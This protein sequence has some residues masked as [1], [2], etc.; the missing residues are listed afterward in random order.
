MSNGASFF[1][2]SKPRSSASRISSAYDDDENA[3]AGPSSSS[4]RLGT[5]KGSTTNS[6]IPSGREEVDHEEEEQGASSVIFRARAKGVRGAQSSSPA[7]SSKTATGR[8]QA[9]SLK[10]RSSA[11]A[12]DEDDA[13]DD[14][15]AI[16]IRRSKPNTAGAQST[17]T[18]PGASSLSTTSTATPKRSTPLRP[19]SFHI[20]A[21]DTVDT[22]SDATSTL[23][24][25]K[26]LEELRSSTPT[27]R[28][29]A[30]SPAGMQPPGPGTRIDDPMVTQTARIALDDSS[31]DTLARNKFAA[32][33][34][35]DA[36]PSESV[37]RAAKEKRARLRRGRVHSH[38][39]GRLYFACALLQV[40][41]RKE[42]RC[43]AGR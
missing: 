43:D 14:G 8:S 22:S 5:A 37:I 7:F 3:E 6:H 20:Q 4:T 27:S 19:T 38:S 33:F 10:Q 31:D 28:S 11:F 41:D 26:Y 40:F 23:Y 34:A 25:S 29:R 39:V 30:H 12:I 21:S 35:H 2:R 15:E 1:K 32:D 36:I 9:P 24:T 13:E 42:V 18:T 17:R 16:K